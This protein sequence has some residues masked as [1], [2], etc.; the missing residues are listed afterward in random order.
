MKV[1]RFRAHRETNDAKNHKEIHKKV[2]AYDIDEYGKLL[3]VAQE[4]PLPSHLEITPGGFLRNLTS[5]AN[6]VLNEIA[7]LSS[8]PFPTTNDGAKMQPFL[9]TLQPQVPQVMPQ[10]AMQPAAGMTPQAAPAMAQMAM[11]PQMPNQA[12][13]MTAVPTLA[14]HIPTGQP[15]PQMM[16]PP[17]MASQPQEHATA[18]INEAL[19]NTYTT[20]SMFTSKSAALNA[21]YTMG[22]VVVCMVGVFLIAGCIVRLR[23]RKQ[24]KSKN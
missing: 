20:P 15:G 8:G 2:P 7:D 21:E 1:P 4:K 24:Q 23:Q 12:P 11:Q 22:I 17:E 10:M 6:Q 19:K 14:Q 16:V 13:I 3:S 18:V 9:S 5:G